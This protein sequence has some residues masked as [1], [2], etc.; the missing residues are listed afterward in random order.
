MTR[1]Q[2]IFTLSH[3][4][5]I[6]FKYFTFFNTYVVFLEIIQNILLTIPFGFGIRFITQ[7]NARDFFWLAIMAGLVIESAQLVISL[8]IGG[9]YRVVDITDM[10]LNTL[11]AL[12]GYS[13]F[14]MFSWLFMTLTQRHGIEHAGISAYVYDVV[15]RA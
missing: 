6:P 10:L 4:N 9:P 7:F 15:N 13:F 12:I 1:E 5:I 14:K 3:V 11:G 2:V 8:G